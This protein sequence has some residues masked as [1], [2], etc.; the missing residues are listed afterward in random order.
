MLGPQRGPLA[1]WP[2]FA[3]KEEDLDTRPIEPPEIQESYENRTGL[4]G[5]YRVLETIQGTG[6]G[7]VKGAMV[8]REEQDMAGLE[9]VRY[10]YS[11]YLLEALM[12]LLAFYPAIRQEEG[13]LDLIP[14]GR[15]GQVADIADAACFLAGEQASYV[16]GQ[17]LF[18]DG[19]YTAIG[20]RRA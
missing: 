11:P 10:Q 15:L 5:R 13:T 2:D 6:S 8:Y 20:I 19:G 9:R 4:R 18:V 3:V 7:I 14:A 12:H 1:L 17:V 16:N